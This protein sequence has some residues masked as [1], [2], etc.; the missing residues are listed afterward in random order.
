MKFGVYHSLYEWF[1]PIYLEDSKTNFTTT[2]YTDI[3]LWPDIKQIINDYKPSLFWS[4]G[5]WEANDTYWKSTELLAWFYNESPVKDEI[6][7]N[8]RWGRGT[9]CHHGDFY[10]CQDRYN[11]GMFSV[12]TYDF[13]KWHR[14]ELKVKSQI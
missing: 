12:Y 13:H 9:G 7:V 4:D 3:K 6:V 8:D 11:P 14:V 10:N 5:D 2:D 1:N